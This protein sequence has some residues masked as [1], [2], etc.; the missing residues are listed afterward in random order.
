MEN[1]YQYYLGSV[2]AL[3][4]LFCFGDESPKF[5]ILFRDRMISMGNQHKKTCSQLEIY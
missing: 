2:Q 5:D 4:F 1:P 3:Y